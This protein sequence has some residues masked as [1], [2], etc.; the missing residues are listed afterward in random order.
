MSAAPKHITPDDP[1]VGRRMTAEEWL[2]LCE[3]TGIKYERH[4][5]VVVR[6]PEGMSGARRDHNR[7]AGATLAYLDRVFAE[8]G[9]VCEVF[10]SDQAV[11]CE[12]LNKDVYPDV[13]AV[14]GEQRFVDKDEDRLLA[15]P[16]L[17]IE[18]QSEST[19]AYDHTD[20][21][22]IYAA[23][24]SVREYVLIDPHRVRAE[25]LRRQ[26]AGWNMQVFTSLKDEVD[27]ASVGVRLPLKAVYRRIDAA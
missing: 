22:E 1:N 5:G 9:D 4:N 18:V 10:T 2:D 17:V 8:A 7:A 23:I 27:L 12:A 13:S 26:E 16:S 20:K 6:P 25:L 15:N 24:P 14:C 19:T 3:A 11:H 21:L